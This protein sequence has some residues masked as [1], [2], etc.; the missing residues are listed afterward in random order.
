MWNLG[1]S[2]FSTIAVI[3]VVPHLALYV[4]TKGLHYTV[5][6]RGDLLRLCAFSRV[7]AGVCSVPTL[8]WK[9][10]PSLLG[11]DVC[12]LEG[13]RC[14]SHLPDGPLRFVTLSVADP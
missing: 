12:R 8:V 2:I 6:P 11:V 4:Y 9:R 1:F 5:R 14:D 3:R 13:M 10:D 7:R